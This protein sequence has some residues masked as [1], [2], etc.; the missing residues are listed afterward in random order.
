MRQTAI[1]LVILISF[2]AAAAQQGTAP[3]FL[4]S[5][6]LPPELDRV[7]RDYEAAWA[8]KDAARLAKL[9]A[10]DGYV[11]PGGSPP[12]KGRAAIETYYTGH[13]GPLFLR[14][15]AFATEGKVGY[16]I[17]GYTG[18]AGSPD[19][20]KFTLT[21]RKGPDGRWLINSDMDNSNRRRQ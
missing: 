20:G 11:L 6:T 18:T 8:A 4:P 9:F 14:A 16:I 3:A 19:E 12:V 15:I 1:I 10:E 17:G 7:L 5:V 13:G 21:L 2:V